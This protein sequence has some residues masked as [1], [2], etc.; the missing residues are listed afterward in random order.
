MEDRT[1]PPAVVSEDEA[2][3][4]NTRGDR[5]STGTGTTRSSTARNGR[6]LENGVAEGNSGSAREAPQEDDIPV[7][8]IVEI[9]R[10]NQVVDGPWADAVRL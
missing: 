6:P 2:S 10:P 8:Q 4:Q 7:A 9:I 3:V 1:N 5:S